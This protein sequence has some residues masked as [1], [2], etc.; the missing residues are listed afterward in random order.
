MNQH[1]IGDGYCDD[2]TNNPS[3]SFDG[4]DCCGPNV[5]TSYCISCQCLN[6]LNYQEVATTL[7]I[8]DGLLPASPAIP[9]PGQILLGNSGSNTSSSIAPT[10][11]PSFTMQETIS[12]P[13]EHD[14]SGKFNTNNSNP[15]KYCSLINQC[16]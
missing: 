10:S 15:R 7:N 1:W 4:N 13:L 8:I 5:E 2:D 6:I 16:K 14:E 11:F 12:V 3:C 9:P